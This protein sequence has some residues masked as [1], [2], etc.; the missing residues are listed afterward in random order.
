MNPLLDPNV[1]Y[2]IL[3]VGFV[4]AILALFAPGTGLLE[5]G[6]LIMLILAGFSVVS[7]PT[8]LWALVLLVFGIIPLLLA[9]RKTGRWYWLAGSLVILVVGTVFLFKTDTG[10]PAINWVLAGVMSVVAIGIIWLIARKGLEAI[11]Q[12]VYSADSLVGQVGEAHTKVFHEGSVYV[13]G[14]EWSARSD[15]PI[16]SG[17]RVLVTGRQGLVIVVEPLKVAQPK[18]K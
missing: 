9:L 17:D 11:R 2:V 18:K 8:N 7:L 13:G 1:A 15:T 6:A 12:P 4:L 10:A 14:E 16:P 5:V 3:V